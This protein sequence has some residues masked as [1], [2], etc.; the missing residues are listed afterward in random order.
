MNQEDLERIATAQC[1]AT[2]HKYML[3]N[4]TCCKDGI[5]TWTGDAYNPSED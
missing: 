3:E 4:C 2:K 1:A 5:P